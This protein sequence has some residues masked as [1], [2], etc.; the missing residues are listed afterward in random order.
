MKDL[1]EIER[2]LNVTNSQDHPTNKMYKVF[3]F[4]MK[5]QAAY[6]EELLNEKNI[7]FEADE[8]MAK[9]TTMYLFGIRK[10]DLDAV[11][12]LNFLVIG[13]FRKPFIANVGFKWFVILLGA[14]VLAL[15][16]VGFFLKK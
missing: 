9:G 1:D 16:L 4:K 6:F 15:A 12:K 11:T 2:R 13:K 10:N 14:S 7:Y 8:E 5:E 3:H